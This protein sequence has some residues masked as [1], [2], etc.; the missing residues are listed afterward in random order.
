MSQKTL[1]KSEERALDGLAASSEFWASVRAG[2]AE[3]DGLTEKQYDRFVEALEK[4]AWRADAPTID[5]KL[6]RN[7]FKTKSGAAKCANRA[8]PFCH[9]AASIVIGAYAYCAD[10][11]AEAQA[12]LDA[13]LEAR[14][15]EHLQEAAE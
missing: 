12:D 13:W 7:K 4:N 10:H 3:Y 14:K 2:Y 9:A 15:Q 1:S 6:V 11:A 8:K 5:G